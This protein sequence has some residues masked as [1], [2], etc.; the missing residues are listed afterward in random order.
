[1]RPA[2]YILFTQ[3]AHRINLAGEPVE[4]ATETL[5]FLDFISRSGRDTSFTDFFWKKCEPHTYEMKRYP[6]Y[7]DCLL[8]YGKG[9]T[10]PEISRNTGVNLPS[11]RKWV[12]FRQK[13]KLAHFLLLFLQ[14]GIPRPGTVWLSVNNTSGHA[15]PLGPFIQVPK[16][17]SNWKDVSLV[18]GQV[19]PLQGVEGEFTPA[20]MLGF[21]VG[22]VIGDSAK[23]RSENWHRHLGIVLS[24]KYVTN[25][26][27]GRFTCLCAQSMG[28]RMHRVSDQ[29]K[30]GHKPYGFYQWVSQASPLVDWIFNVC[31]GLKDGERTTYDAV[32][33]DWVLESPLD[34]RVGLVQG[35]AESDG[36]V[37]IASQTVEFWIG[38]NW[39]FFKGVLLTFGVKSFQNREALSVTKTQVVKLGSIPAFSPVLKTVRYLRFLKLVNAKHIQ[40]GRRIPVEI[41]DFIMEN[42]ARESVPRI[43]EKVLDRFGVALSFESVQRW[44]EKAEMRPI[45][46]A[47]SNSYLDC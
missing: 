19:K 8:M 3:N 11:V 37:S 16:K 24:K 9:K 45:A 39:D 14:L 33:M 6:L 2:L 1:M 25:E 7:V 46:L 44:V 31:L 34:F 40:H 20:Y 17:I 36:S 5:K 29:P 23:S 43:S 27:I 32:R 4:R 12:T 13:P 47:K 41:R 30:P 18:L 42:S 26:K 22:M 28:L 35:I 15:I 21:L 10:I 38:P